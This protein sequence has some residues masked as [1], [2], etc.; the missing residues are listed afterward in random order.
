MPPLASLLSQ[1]SLVF[2]STSLLCYLNEFVRRLTSLRMKFKP[3]T[4]DPR[5]LSGNLTFTKC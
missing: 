4:P 3:R 5:D 2:H 1:V